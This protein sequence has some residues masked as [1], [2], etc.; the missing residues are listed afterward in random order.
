MNEFSLFLI[1]RDF[2]K[3][4]VFLLVTFYVCGA[5]SLDTE[6]HISAFFNLSYEH[7]LTPCKEL[8]SC[9]CVCVFS[10]EVT[11]IKNI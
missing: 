5:Y 8:F 10:Y 7:K 11:I 4:T 3:K 1:S 2:F 9:V 6:I